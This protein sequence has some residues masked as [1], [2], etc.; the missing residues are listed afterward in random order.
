MRPVKDW[1]WLMEDNRRLVVDDS[2][3]VNQDW[4]LV[5]HD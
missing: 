3:S 1:W 2:W 4:R 5:N